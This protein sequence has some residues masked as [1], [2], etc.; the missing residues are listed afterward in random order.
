MWL[1]KKVGA[2]ECAPLVTEVAGKKREKESE[3]EI[4][5]VL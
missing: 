5:I 4:G 2:V 3:K 1:T